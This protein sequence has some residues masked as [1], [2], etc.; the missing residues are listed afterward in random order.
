[1]K[2]KGLV[3]IL[4]MLISL[5]ARIPMA[6]AVNETVPKPVKDETKA[7]AQEV[8]AGSEN[9]ALDDALADFE[10]KADDTAA[11]KAGEEKAAA[12]KTAEEPK[13]PEAVKD[14]PPAQNADAGAPPAEAA[15]KE[16]V[17][18]QYPPDVKLSQWGPEIRINVAPNSGMG[19]EKMTAIQSVKMETEKGEYLGLKTFQPD[20]KTR[21]AEFMLNPDILKIDAVKLTVS[22]KT[23]GDWVKTVA[24][25]LAQGGTEAAAPAAAPAQSKPAAAA[26]AKPAKK[27][28]FW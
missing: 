13:G 7:P 28:W 25:K 5:G 9:G 22:S 2:A 14:L 17:W 19:S 21:E 23:D 20:E 11:T 1:M 24:L 15:K 4:I 26:P 6:I 8:K 16:P 3:I 27:G 10:L 18:N 12:P